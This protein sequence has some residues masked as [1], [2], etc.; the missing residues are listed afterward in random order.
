M[1][2]GL[3]T[4]LAAAAILMTA[5]FG[6]TRASAMPVA[7]LAPAVEQAGGAQ[8]DNVR[9]VCGPYRCRWVPNRFYGP[10]RFY[11]PRRF[12]GPGR[13]YGPRRFHGHGRW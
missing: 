3:K 6:A 12:Y 10:P 1:S 11:G 4:A 13:F 9:W 8:I 5:G 2:M 7:G